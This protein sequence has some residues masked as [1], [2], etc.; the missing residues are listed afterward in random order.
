M[1]K[2][3]SFLLCISR[4]VK[5]ESGKKMHSMFKTSTCTTDLGDIQTDEEDIM[6][7]GTT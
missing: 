7:A 6:A 3:P 1:L 5:G 2:N 4:V